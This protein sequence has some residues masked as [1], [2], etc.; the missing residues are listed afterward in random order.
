MEPAVT[1]DGITKRFPGVV[2]NDDVDLVVERGSV[3]ARRS[4]G[5][6]D[7]RPVRSA[8]RATRWPA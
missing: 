5:Y 4:P 1:L 6:A 7:R 2:A 8:S 3:H